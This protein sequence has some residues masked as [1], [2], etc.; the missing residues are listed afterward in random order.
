MDEEGFLKPDFPAD[1]FATTVDDYV[2]YRVPYPAEL[3]GDLLARIGTTGSGRLLDLACGPGRASLP[4]AGSFQ[5]IWAVDLEPKMIAAARRLASER[6]ISNV[7][8]FAGRAEDLEAP[9]VHFD[10]ITIGEA[11]H[12]LDQRLIAEKCLFWLRPGGFLATIG[13]YT[14]LGGAA[15][16]QRAIAEV[17]LKW[18]G[19]DFPAILP[20]QPEKNSGPRHDERALLAAGFVDV[21][22]HPFL[23]EF[24][25]TVESIAG[26]L[27]STSICSR[28]V[29]GQYA[30]A[31]VADLHS[32][33]LAHD[34]GGRFP[35][36]I[37]F[38]YTLARKP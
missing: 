6:R 3:M 15:P 16:W 21:S 33:L 25:W 19:R 17:V 2:R 34:P 1:A 38:G 36:Q 22:S 37:R 11:F 30:D 24:N 18:T 9:P 28:K 20:S 7:K 23:Q 29:L 13:S 8:W 26:F 35:D 27:F 10:L 31:F 5:E 32:A 12:R 4:L 14:L